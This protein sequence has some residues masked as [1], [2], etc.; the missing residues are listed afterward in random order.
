MK[1][2]DIHRY[3][4]DRVKKLGGEV[5]RVKW[6]GRSHAPDVLCLMPGRHFY[7]EEKRPNEDARPGQLREHERMRA[8]GCEVVVLDTIE[9][10]DAYLPLTK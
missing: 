8:A 4:V 3:L 5:R 1:E 7:T 2:R 9:K 6:I 10:I